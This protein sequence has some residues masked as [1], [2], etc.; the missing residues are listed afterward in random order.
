MIISFNSWCDV[1]KRFYQLINVDVDVESI[2]SCRHFP[3]ATESRYVIASNLTC[4][5]ISPNRLLRDISKIKN[6]HRCAW[7]SDAC[8]NNPFYSYAPINVKPAGRQ[9]KGWGFDIFQKFAVKFPAHG[10]I[11]P[12]KCNQI[13]PPRAAHC[14]PIS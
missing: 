1:C 3:L 4:M 13:S 11:I 5:L 12:V 7:Y 14:Y 6:K 2:D 9:G 10:Q 8:Q